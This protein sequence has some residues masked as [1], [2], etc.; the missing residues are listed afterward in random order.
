M[1]THYEVLI[2]RRQLHD[3]KPFTRVAKRREDFSRDPEVRVA[4]V[5]TL[6]HFWETQGKTAKI[7]WCHSIFM[8]KADDD[9]APALGF[10]ADPF[11][12]RHEG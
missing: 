3:G 10:D 1:L 5:F 9:A 11:F 2:L 12:A 6:D 7:R 8:W 4:L